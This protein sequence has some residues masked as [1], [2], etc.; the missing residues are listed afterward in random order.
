MP[1]REFS[2]Q[3]SKTSP[4]QYQ[5]SVK[6]WTV[7]LTC[8]VLSMFLYSMYIIYIYIIIVYFLAQ[9]QEIQLIHTNLAVSIYLQHNKILCAR[10]WTEPS[11]NRRF[12]GNNVIW[13]CGHKDSAQTWRKPQRPVCAT[14]CFEEK[15]TSY[16]TYALDT[17]SVYSRCKLAL[18]VALFRETKR[19]QCSWGHV[20]AGPR[21]FGSRSW[22][23][24]SCSVFFSC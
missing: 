1:N 15:C 16:S 11:P 17:C 3:L 6:L 21:C 23:L 20:R 14:S 8:R 18:Y 22:Q 4:W 10:I 13:T 12:Q 24:G 9:P 7:I 19:P 5:S 2:Q